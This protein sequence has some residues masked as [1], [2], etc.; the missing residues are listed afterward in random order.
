MPIRTAHWI[1]GLVFLQVAL[2]AFVAGLKAGL[3][4]NTWPLMNGA[5]LPDDLFSMSPLLANFFDNATTVQ[6][7]HRLVAYLV[8]GVAI[9][10][11]LSVMRLIADPVLRQSALL[12][13]TAVSAQAMLGI[14]TL[15]WAVPL[16]LGIAHQAGAAVVLAISVRHLFLMRRRA[17]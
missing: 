8:L 5:V 4:Y 7:N 17:A 1:V 11:A 2:G 6:F 13:A 3:H 16:H 14:V 12:L 9:W 15:L 10:H